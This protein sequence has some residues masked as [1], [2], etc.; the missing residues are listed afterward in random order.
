MRRENPIE[1]LE[2]KMKTKFILSALTL[3]S[4]AFSAHAQTEKAQV[5]AK[6]KQVLVALI[7]KDAKTL[8]THVHPAKGVRFSPY[9]NIDTQKDLTFR[10]KDVVKIYT[11][12]A[13]VWGQA[14]GSGDD[15]KLDFAGYYKKFVYDKDFA[16]APAVGYNRVVKQGNAIVNVAEA[17][18]NGKF[19]EYHFPGTKKD[20]GMDWKSLR[21]I[22]EKAGKNW[23][24]VGISHDEWTI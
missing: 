1:I 6:S 12:P 17:Y 10:R 21:L 15:I 9:G 24:L 16:R 18:P 2:K 8:A 3:L 5:L 22:F 19:V 23:Y 11:L 14:D 7:N 20:S 13:Y 4:L